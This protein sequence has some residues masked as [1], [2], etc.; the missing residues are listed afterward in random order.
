MHFECPATN[1]D[2]YKTQIFEFALVPCPKMA[3]VTVDPVSFREHFD[4]VS[5]SQYVLRLRPRRRIA[6][7]T[8]LSHSLGSL[9]RLSLSILAG[10]WRAG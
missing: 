5:R 9:N 10:I 7:D 6:C 4:A 3:T 1:A 8:T 2:I